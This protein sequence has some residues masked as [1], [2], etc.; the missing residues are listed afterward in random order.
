MHRDKMNPADEMARAS[1]RLPIERHTFSAHAVARTDDAIAEEMPV[2]LVFNGISHAVMM[3]TPMDLEDF[4]IGFSLTEQIVDRLDQIYDMECVQNSAAFGIEVRISIA[5]ACFARLKHKRRSLSGK[6]GCGL[7]GLESL[8][9]LDLATPVV[10]KRPQVSKSA[11]KKAFSNLQARQPVNALTGA[12]H[13][14]AWVDLQGD[15]QIVREDVG[16]HNAL[17]KLIGA[18]GTDMQGKNQVA[19]LV[20]GFALMTSRASYELLQKAARADIAILATI[21]APTTLAI[22]IAEQA[23]ICLIGFVRQQGFVV[24]SHPGRLLDE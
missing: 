5:S 7:C 12:L 13:A 14:A 10:T 3:A 24:Y 19:P 6:T 8:T 21:S 9:A 4:A 18:L 23:G 20:A 1:R 11:L 2:A 15:I 16:R 22:R 17:D